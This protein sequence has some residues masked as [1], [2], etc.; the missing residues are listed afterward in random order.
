RNYSKN[1]ALGTTIEW[2]DVTWNPVSGCTKITRGCDNCYAERIAERFRGVP[3]HPFENGFDL[4]LREHKLSE[5]LKW[6]T[7]RRIFVNSMSDLFH[8]EILT[9]VPLLRSV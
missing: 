6:R 8:K 3:N 2:T 9:W 1:M 5:P 7:P 4:T